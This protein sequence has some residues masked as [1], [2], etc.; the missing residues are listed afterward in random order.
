MAA[1]WGERTLD[2]IAAGD[3]EAMQRQIAATARSRRNSR[4]GRHAG[5]QVI[6]PARAVYNR[7][8][9]DGLIDAAASPP[10]GWSSRVGY[11]APAAP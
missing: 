2:A 7:A 8:I 6:A 10:T 9:V 1:V 11:R 3:I 5:E 4:G